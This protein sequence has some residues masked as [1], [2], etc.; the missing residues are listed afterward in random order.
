MK[1]GFHLI[2]FFFATTVLIAQ[3]N[4]SGRLLAGAAEAIINPPAGTYLAGY[5]QNRKSTGI[6][7]DL[8]VKAVVVANRQNALVLVTI[9]CI[10]LPYPVVQQIRDA[11]ELKLPA[12]AFNAGHIVNSS[13]NT[14][15]RPDLIGIWGADL[16]HTGTDSS[17]MKSLVNTA[18]AVIAKAW[19][20][21][22]AVVAKY[23]DTAF[24][25]GWVENVSDSLEIDR[26]VAVVQ[27]ATPRGKNIA[28]LTNF[29]CHPTFLG[30]ENTLVSADFPSGFYKQM[31]A[32][33]GGINLYVQ[34]AI[35]GW[36]Q[37]EKVVRT[38]EEAEQKG[39]A[40]AGAVSNALKQSKPLTGNGVSF[41]SSRFE[42]PVNNKALKQLA[43]AGIIS[44]DISEGTPTEIAWFSIGNAVFATHPGE[45]S[46]LYSFATKKLM[47]NKGPKFIL[48]L[49]Q[50]ELGYILKP[51]FFDPVT[52]LH[53]ATYLTGM[54]PAKEAGATMMQV[55]SDLAEKNNGR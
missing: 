8:F 9:D 43:T 38:F 34:G 17:Y 16:M 30:K 23:A 2:V 44:R 22:R 29:A 12:N 5:G 33:L 41:S 39:K 48:G 50:D 24:G 51:E 55:L 14:H 49:G 53:A 54:S 47:T 6:H 18:T 28:T 3:P 36:V 4:E 37:P 35:G 20:R 25:E 46:P 19:K 11:V 40:L 52:K 10:G 1:K 26:S 42:M 13:T 31:N 27:F 21:K 45:T 7:D 15:S 32:K